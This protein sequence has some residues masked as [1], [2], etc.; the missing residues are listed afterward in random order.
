MPEGWA[1][2]R[3][4]SIRESVRG[5]KEEDRSIYSIT[6]GVVKAVLASTGLAFDQFLVWRSQNNEHAK[7]EWLNHRR[8]TLEV[9][10]FTRENCVGR[11]MALHI[12]NVPTN[13]LLL[14]IILVT[15]CA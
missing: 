2:Q 1:E 9:A 13:G 7:Q 15:V 6:E 4:E 12:E 3:I 5:S 14:R 8:S 11:R 10:D